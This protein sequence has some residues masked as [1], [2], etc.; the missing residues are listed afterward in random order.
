MTECSIVDDDGLSRATCEV[1]ELLRALADGRRRLLVSVLEARDHGWIR[2]ERLVAI[3][4]GRDDRLTAADWRREFVHVHCP[5]LADLGLL[6]HDEQ[7]DAVR[8]YRC[9]LVSEL[10]ALVEA[11]ADRT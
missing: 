1:D 8:Y 4:A 7:S 9:D 11:R 10:L 5:V 3:L 2:R 6:E